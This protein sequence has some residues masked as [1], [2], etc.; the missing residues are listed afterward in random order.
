MKCMFKYVDGFGEVHCCQMECRA[1]STIRKCCKMIP[2][3]ADELD[4]L[5]LLKQ[6]QR[7]VSR[8]LCVAEGIDPEMQDPDFVDMNA[9][10]LVDVQSELSNHKYYAGRTYRNTVMGEFPIP[11]KGQCGD[12]S[13]KTV[14]IYDF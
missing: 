2:A 6:T 12:K 4:R 13:V 10:H 11:E 5:E 3:E 1:W 8:D 7:Q 14:D 9:D